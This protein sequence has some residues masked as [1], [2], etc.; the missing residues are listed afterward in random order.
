MENQ[1]KI[2]V[3]NPHLNDPKYEGVK[4]TFEHWLEEFNCVGYSVKEDKKISYKRKYDVEEFY[5]SVV[6][7]LKSAIVSDIVKA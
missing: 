6:P 2:L 5:E 4:Q 3:G 7:K 1:L